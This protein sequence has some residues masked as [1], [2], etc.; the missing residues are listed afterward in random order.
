MTHLATLAAVVLCLASG[1]RINAQPNE[2]GDAEAHA[3]KGAELMLAQSF[4]DAQ[5]EFEKALTL[6]PK[7]T[8]AR[9]QLGACYFAQG[10][11]AE[12]R[13]EFERVQ[14]EAG[15]SAAVEYYLGRLDLLAND[16]DGAIHRLMP[17][18]REPAYPQATFYLGMAYVSAGDVKSGVR[19]LEDAAKKLPHDFRGYRLARAYTLAGRAEDAERELKLYSEF[20]DEQ[21]RTETLV[22]DC[23]RARLRAGR[24]NH[25]R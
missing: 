6:D 21:K 16:Y 7:L 23:S 3:G 12:A 2:T 14:R 20:T 18:A 22:R 4:T 1:A 9:L 24:P 19:W 8:R 13:R 10:L 17:L 11:N 5:A 15:D 25:R